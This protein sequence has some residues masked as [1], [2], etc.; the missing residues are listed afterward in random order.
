[1]QLAVLATFVSAAAALRVP[2]ATA[3]NQQSA[4]NALPTRRAAV[5][6]LGLVASLQLASPAA[7]SKF[8]QHVEDFARAV[9][10]ADTVAVQKALSVLALP[11]DTAS[12]SRAMTKSGD[13]VDLTP[14]ASVRLGATSA[15]VTV[16]V[17]HVQKA[18]DYIR[19][20]WLQ[21]AESGGLLGVR[22]FKPTEPATFVGSIPFALGKGLTV[23]PC[24]YSEAHGVWV[25]E[26]VSTA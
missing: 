9:S 2:G 6:S 22:E 16:S 1:M 8:P 17:P 18:D 7:A 12:A 13:A 20:M 4:L 25:G 5:A 19:Y 11:S 23:V 15:K 3:Q 14:T 10:A 24:L 21:N 26:P